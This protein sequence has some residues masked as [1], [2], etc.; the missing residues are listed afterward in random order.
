MEFENERQNYLSQ[1]MNLQQDLNKALEN[2][3]IR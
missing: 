2:S 1:I 3:M